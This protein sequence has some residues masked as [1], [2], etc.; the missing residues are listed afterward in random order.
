MK[1]RSSV[2]R[3]AMLDRHKGVGPNGR[4]RCRLCGTEVATKRQRW[5]S[6]ACVETYKMAAWPEHARHKVFERDHGVCGACGL[7]TMALQR[8]AQRIWRLPH[9]QRGSGVWSVKVV[10]RDVPV[11]GHLWEAHHIKAFVEGGVVCGLDNYRT[12]CLWCHKAETASMVRKR[13]RAKSRQIA[14]PENP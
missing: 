2:V 5:C 9:G 7:D 13:A 14:L 10:E 1:S 11:Y 6:P 4:P 8:E 12:L 3:L